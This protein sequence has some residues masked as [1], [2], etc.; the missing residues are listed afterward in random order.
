[1]RSPKDTRWT[2]HSCTACCRGFQFGPVERE[3]IENL[4]QS[5]VANWWKPAANTPWYEQRGAPGATPSFYFRSI[6]GHCIFLRDDGLCAIH[7]QLG[8]SKKPG[9]CREF[10]YHIVEE[11]SGSVG[12]IR[13]ECEGWHRSFQN[14][15]PI[16]EELESVKALPRVVPRRRFDGESVLLYP[17]AEISRAHWEHLE[18]EFLQCLEERARGVEGDLIELRNILFTLTGKKAPHHDTSAYLGLAC[19]LLAPIESTLQHVLKQPKGDPHQ[20]TFTQRS[21]HRVQATMACLQ[22]GRLPPPKAQEAEY[23]N[24]VLQNWILGKRF[25]EIGPL[26]GGLGSFALGTLVARCAAAEAPSLEGVAKHYAGWL[27]FTGIPMVQQL[28]SSG[29]PALHELFLRTSPAS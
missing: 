6:D 25:L 11:V 19:N 26:S 1:M 3:V 2:C 14:G 15:P 28:L 27:R 29:L 9:F 5:E 4:Q 8:E 23:F 24:Q 21:L 12:V 7:A 16:A 17:R 20:V 18:S 22:E 10:P 13:A